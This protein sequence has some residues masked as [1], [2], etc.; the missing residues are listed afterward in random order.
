MSL[1]IDLRNELLTYLEPSQ[2]EVIEK[3]FKLAEQA[4]EKQVRKSGEPYITHPLAVAHIL[5]SLKMD[6]QSIAAAILHDVIEDTPIEKSQIIAEFGE[7]IANL[8]DGV[9]K[10]SQIEFASRAEAQAENFRKMILAMTKDIR[11]ILVKLA[12][13]LHNMRTLHGLS[14]E[15]RRQKALETL[16]IYAPIAYRLGIHAIKNELEDLGFAAL[17]PWRFHILENAL[18]KLFRH[19]KEILSHIESNIRTTLEKHNLPSVAIWGRRKH[20]YSIYQ[21][22]QSKQLPFNE[23]MDVYAFRIVVDS[24]DTCYRVLGVVHNLY[25]P[26]P[27][28]FKDY[29]A[30]PKTNG[31]QS[32]HTTLFGPQG[33]P[34]EIQIRTMDMD[35]VA[36][37]GV[38]AHWLYKTGPNEAQLRARGWLKGLMELQNT[39]GSSLEFIENVKIDLFPEEVYVFTPK[40]DILELPQGATPVDF[41]YAV[42]S[43]IGNSCIAA[44]IDKR[45]SPLSTILANGQTLE[46]ITAPGAQ[47]NPAWLNFV[48]T[49]KARSHIKNYLKDL[50]RSESIHFGQRL[51]QQTLKALKQP[52]EKIPDPI[53]KKTL[54]HFGYKS[55]EDLFAAIGLGNEMVALVALQ[56]TGQPKESRKKRR[57]LLIKGT[58]GIVVKFANCCGPIPGDPIVGIFDRGHGL[59][60]HQKNCPKGQIPSQPEHYLPLKWEEIVEGEFK[61]DIK[62]EVR[63]QRGILAQLTNAINLEDANI[64]DISIEERDGNYYVINLIITVRDRHQLAQVFKHIRSIKNVSKLSRKIG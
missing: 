47:P 7:E 27:E 5:S 44:K 59:I 52:L 17:Y 51:L 36:E 62:V 3:A 45:L 50:K 63:S 39:T 14:S 9:S 2:V 41:A 22:M 16:E 38:A 54:D 23:V 11:V 37:Q 8:V 40:G 24:T 55:P 34:I 32:L 19:R 15:K 33:I 49:S 12:D 30:I 18:N 48:A 64:E 20:I 58:E 56:L 57:S 60:I 25:K 10:L 53:F 28:R 43:D 26:V 13:R 6:Y 1:F 4:H 42:H 35:N 29:I 46:I 61:T 21:K 31:Y